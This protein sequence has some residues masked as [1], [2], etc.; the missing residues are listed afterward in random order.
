MALAQ[1][2]STGLRVEDFRVVTCG[3]EDRDSADTSRDQ[4]LAG[5]KHRDGGS[6]PPDGHLASSQSEAAD[7][8][9][10]RGDDRREKTDCRDQ[11][12]P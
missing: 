6:A 5:R 3:E 7:R 10:P 9:R 2:E 4:D 11:T 1:S 8:R 12:N